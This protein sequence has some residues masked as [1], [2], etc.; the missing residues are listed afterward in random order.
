MTGDKVEEVVLLCSSKLPAC[1]RLITNPAFLTLSKT[2]GLK[3][4]FVDDE[5]TR[6]LLIQVDVT[7]L[8]L[9]ILKIDDD[10][11]HV[12]NVGYIMKVLHDLNKKKSQ[13]PVPETSSVPQ[14][15]QLF[16]VQTPYK[17]EE[18]SVSFIS[19][20]K[21]MTEDNRFD[22]TVISENCR[23][24][25]FENESYVSVNVTNINSLKQLIPLLQDKRRILTVSKTKRLADLVAAMCM[26]YIQ[27]STLD[28]IQ[29]TT[30][31]P[32][33][34]LVDLFDIADE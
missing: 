16:R 15:N 10:I 8:P 26:Y 30:S 5:H 32:K 9:L 22:L 7:T 27:S 33:K 29:N 19:C 31:I 20:D 24:V 21:F 1:Y 34:T 12:K 13:Q 25:H 11:L 3:T 14:P 18:F 17:N 28:E 4:I 2:S 6:H 23:K